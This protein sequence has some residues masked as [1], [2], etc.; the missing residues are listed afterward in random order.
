MESYAETFN[1]KLLRLSN[2][3]KKFHDFPDFLKEVFPCE[4]FLR[5]Y[6][7]FPGQMCEEFS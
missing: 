3:Q 2:F 6:L 4:E 5:T 7:K 1:A